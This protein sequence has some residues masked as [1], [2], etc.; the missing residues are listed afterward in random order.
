MLRADWDCATL[1]RY[2]RAV[3]EAADPPIE[4]LKHL[5]APFFLGRDGG[6][7]VRSP[8]IAKRKDHVFSIKEAFLLLH[9]LDIVVQFFF[10]DCG[11]TA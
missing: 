5:F 6:L 2:M 10:V 7:A 8:K 11:V 9:S 4:P 3:R 1:S